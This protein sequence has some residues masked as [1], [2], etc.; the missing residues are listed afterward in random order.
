MGDLVVFKYGDRRT[1][2]EVVEIR[3]SASQFVLRSMK[4][5]RRKTLDALYAWDKLLMAQKIEDR[6]AQKLMRA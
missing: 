6:I 1:R 2:W 3:E 5:G 4:S